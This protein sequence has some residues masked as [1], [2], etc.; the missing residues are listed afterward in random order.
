MR[1]VL[2]TG[3]ALFGLAL[4]YGP[5]GL[6]GAAVGAFVGFVFAEI[7]AGRA[8]VA[9][10]EREV[11]SLRRERE[12][13][14]REEAARS[15][16]AQARPSSASGAGTPG[17]KPAAATS[18]ARGSPEA[19]PGT[20]ATTTGDSSKPREAQP[21]ATDL[22]P[23]ASAPPT[24]ATSS[25]RTAPITEGPASSSPRDAAIEAAHASPGVSQAH[26]EAP[27]SLSSWKRQP[28]PSEELAVVKAI[29]EYFTGGNTLVRVGVVILFIGVA[30][31]LRYVAEHTHVPIEFRL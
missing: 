24:A 18:A 10:L 4:A 28:P 13:E 7:A 9:E 30:F 15:A 31:L 17:P 27:E 3:G 21:Q 16:S 23:G 1:F 6:Y 11:E 29:R 14:K 19:P 2:I 5:T 22:R 25:A 26:A 20:V 12:K 8:R